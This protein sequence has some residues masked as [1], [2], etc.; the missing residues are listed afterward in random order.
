L[1]DPEAIEKRIKLEVE[2]EAGCSSRIP[3]PAFSRIV[4]NLCSNGIHASPEGSTVSL[5]VESRGNRISIL[6]R[7]SGAGIPE[8]NR[9]NIFKP[10]FTTKGNKGTGLGLYVV[11]HVCEL[12]GGRVDFSSG[13]NGTDFLL[14]FPREEISI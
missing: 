10:D 4:E 2:A 13:A 14:E 8:A 11:K 5:K 9:P 3:A 7:D 12:Y 6:V 1:S